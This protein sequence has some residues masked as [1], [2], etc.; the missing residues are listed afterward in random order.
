M[1]KSAKSEAIS[2][3]TPAPPSDFSQPRFDPLSDEV[4]VPRRPRE[5]VMIPMRRIWERKGSFS[6]DHTPSDANLR[7]LTK[8]EDAL[9]REPERRSALKTLLGLYKRRGELDHADLLTG[10]WIE[11]EPLDPD[12]LT[13]RADS[14]AARGKRDDAIRQ[15]G[16]VL[17]AR[18]DDVKAQQ[19][20]A[21]LHRWSGESE[22][23]CRYWI[24]LSEFHQDKAEWLVQAVRCSRG[25]DSAW[26]GDYL[27]SN[28]TESVRQQAER[29]LSKE[30]PLADV[31]SGDLRVDA[32]WAGDTDID[33]AFITPEGQRVSWLGAPTRQV[34]S[35]RGV[36]SRRSES[37]A[38]RNAPAGNYVIELVRVTG[39]GTARGELALTVADLRRSVPFTLRDEHLVAGVATIRVVPKLVPLGVY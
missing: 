19:R 5:R 3:P 10:R 33:I 34:I 37:L 36:T 38:M 25:G 12:A 35:A 18:P 21:R 4:V 14:A 15:L 16:S 6:G 32:E 29:E 13:A 9:D 24:A 7:A 23:S 20:L 22:Q 31:L 26:L 27:L 2:P 30:P 39:S 17:D 28:A 1:R 8:A 11:K